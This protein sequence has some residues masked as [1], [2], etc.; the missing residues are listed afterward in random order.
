[1]NKVRPFLFAPL[2]LCLLPFSVQAAGLWLY[3]QAAPDMGLAAAGRA[4]LAND[5][6]TAASNPAG[7]TRLDRNQL[8]GGFLGILVKAKFDTENSS[9][10]GGDGGDAGG[11]VPAG[12]F[13]YVHGLT[14]DLKSGSPLAQILALG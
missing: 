8:E 4:A 1:M 5:A 2:F 14:P 9:F 12:S 7:M 11:F 3:E 6:S 10:S 13:S